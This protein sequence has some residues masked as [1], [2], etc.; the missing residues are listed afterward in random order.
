MVQ[1]AGHLGEFNAA[2]AAM[3]GAERSENRRTRW[4]RV[5]ER[6]LRSMYLIGIVLN[7]VALVYAALDGAL[8]FAG[9]FGL[10]MA[11]LGVRY[12]MVVS[13]SGPGG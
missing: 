12:W 11:Y 10:V 9:T 3:A 8:L 4:P 1:R 13:D 5:N 7:A 6:R 2:L